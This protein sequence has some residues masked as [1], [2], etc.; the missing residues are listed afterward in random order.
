[1]GFSSFLSECLRVRLRQA[2]SSPKMNRP[3]EQ[4]GSPTPPP[5]LDHPRTRNADSEEYTRLSG[6]LRLH[7]SIPIIE[8]LERDIYLR[9]PK[10][11]H[12]KKQP[13][14]HAAT[15]AVFGRKRRNACLCR[16]RLARRRHS[17]LR[18]RPDMVYR[19]QRRGLIETPKEG[20]SRPGEPC[21][22]LLC[23][24][25]TPPGTA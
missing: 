18:L 4:M 6:K 23:I 10:T 20:S 3:T 8:Q 19:H 25:P 9:P 17:R 7:T 14:N 5:D 2:E 12:R 13:L 1:M 24:R 21:K 15:S 11:N 16:H 22:R